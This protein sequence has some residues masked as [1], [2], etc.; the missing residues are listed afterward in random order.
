MSWDQSWAMED[1]TDFL[2]RLI[3]FDIRQAILDAAEKQGIR[4][5]TREI[6][7][8]NPD[9]FDF[10]THRRLTLED[11]R[12]FEHKLVRSDTGD[13]WGHDTYRYCLA[14]DPDPLVYRTFEGEPILPGVEE[15]PD[16]PRTDS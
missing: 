9:D 10:A 5:K 6:L 3:G 14:S 8:D 1:E 15:D 4:I 2:A 7:H 13:D 12:V 11:G 16:V